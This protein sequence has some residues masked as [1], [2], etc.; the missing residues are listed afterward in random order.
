MSNIIPNVIPN[1]DECIIVTTTPPKTPETLTYSL[2]RNV[3]LDTKGDLPKATN[4]KDVKTSMFKWKL[5]PALPRSLSV[6]KIDDESVPNS[7]KW[8]SRTSKRKSAI[9]A[10]NENSRC[11]KWRQ[12]QA[13]RGTVGV[14]PGALVKNNKNSLE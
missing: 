2:S 11:E 7:H 4:T 12:E 3:T 14:I 5:E 1:K 8:I 6:T 9:K 10:D 13:R